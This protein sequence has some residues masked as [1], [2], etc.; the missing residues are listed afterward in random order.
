MAARLGSRI[1]TENPGGVNLRY[2]L[3]WHVKRRIFFVI[4]LKHNA[5]FEDQNPFAKNITAVASDP[6]LDNRNI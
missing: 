1:L 5:A 3:E 2:P 4:Y 6:S